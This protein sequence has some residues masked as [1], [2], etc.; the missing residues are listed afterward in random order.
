MEGMGIQDIVYPS[1]GTLEEITLEE[2]KFHYWL[3]KF[4]NGLSTSQQ[5]DFL[6]IMN[7]ISR[8]NLFES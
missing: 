2:S 7:D 4:L 8:P 1:L 6:D 3:T 5:N